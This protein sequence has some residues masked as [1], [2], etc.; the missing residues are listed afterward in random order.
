[1]SQYFPKPY[2]SFKGKV[3]VKLDLFSYVTKAEWKNTAGVDTS[4]LTSKSNLAGLKAEADKIDVHKLKTVL[5]DLIK[6]SNVVNN[7]VVKK[8]LC[9]IFSC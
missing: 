8:K 2:R 1:M 3:K 5:V 4:K 6:L 9:I 7:E